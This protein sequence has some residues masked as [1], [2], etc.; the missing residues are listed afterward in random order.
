MSLLH[1]ERLSLN[2]LASE[3]DVALSTVW[4]WTQSGVRGHRLESF[5]VGGRRYTTRAAYER[6]IAT[7][8]G[9]VPAHVPAH[10]QRSHQ[11]AMRSLAAKGLL[12]PKVANELLSVEAPAAA[13]P[14]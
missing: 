6:W 1:D 12:A 4:R 8:N 14:R 13:T 5:H 11:A 2:E 3:Q 9:G 7:L 10:R